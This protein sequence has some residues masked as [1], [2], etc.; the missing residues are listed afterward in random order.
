MAEA[1]FQVD[2]KKI[3]K[4]IPCEQLKEYQERLKYETE[5]IRKKGFIDYTLTVSD[6]L[7]ACEKKGI[8]VGCGRGSGAGSIVNYL[9]N[10]T[11]IDPIKYNLLF[12]RYLNIARKDFPDI[13]S[14][15][16][17]R[18]GCVDVIKELF[19]NKEI[20][21]II[22]KNR[23]QLKKLVKSV[24]KVL[25]IRFPRAYSSYVDNADYY[26]KLIESHEITSVNDFFNMKEVDGLEQYVSHETGLEIKEIFSLFHENIDSL[27]IHAGGVCILPKEQSNVSYT[28]VKNE[29]YSYATSYSESGGLVELEQIG[30]I[31]FDFLGL[32]TLS[33]IERCL[34]IISK[35]TG[36]SFE[37]LSEDIVKLK[38]VDLNDRKVY[39]VIQ[40]LCTEGMFQIGSSGMKEFV[41]LIKPDN[42]EEL[43]ML[44]ALYRPGPMMSGM[45]NKVKAVKFQEED[46]L[47][48]WNQKTDGSYVDYSHIIKVFEDIIKPTYYSV[49]YEEQVMQIGQRIADY[50]DAELN[51]FRKFLKTSNKAGVDQEKKKQFYGA[52]IENGIKKGFESDVLE[53]L[54]EKLVNFSAYSFNKCLSGDTM[55]TTNTGLKNIRKFKSGDK[56]VSFH[57]LLKTYDLMYI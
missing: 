55:V 3:V 53:D 48:L 34:R 15:V 57:F 50:S 31:K 54:W 46:Y 45:Q 14:D 21:V 24:F 23:M 5:I 41:N 27:G 17:W 1:H 19:P 10:I 8:I 33:L 29:V 35:T 20:T 39:D 9:L 25:N 49:I 32:G 30:E 28:P 16:S 26:S 40:N 6:V 51:N 38:N 18:E 11:N 36:I 37:K 42:I 12:S 22:N 43:C 47:D 44:V 52:F 4:K 56:A 2:N 13:D 7:E